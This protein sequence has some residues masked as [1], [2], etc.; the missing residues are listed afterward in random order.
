M[1][2]PDYPQIPEHMQESIWRYVNDRVPMGHFLEALF[3]N[4]L[5]EAFGRADDYNKSI[6]FHYVKLVYNKTPMGCHGSKK[7]VEAWLKGEQN[8]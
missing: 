4:D 5:M 2:Y 8:G 1:R 7:A 6:M 3:S